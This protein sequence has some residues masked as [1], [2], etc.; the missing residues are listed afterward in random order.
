MAHQL[1]IDLDL[2]QDLD[3]DQEVRED[4][5]N[6]VRVQGKMKFCNFSNNIQTEYHL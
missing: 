2:A 4:L 5:E 3:V 1:E 6:H